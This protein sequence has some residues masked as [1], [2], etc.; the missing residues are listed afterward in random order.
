[1][2]RIYLSIIALC[3]LALPCLHAVPAKPGP[4]K[5]TLPDGTV[6]TIFL[7]G[8]EF[9][10]WMTDAKGSVVEWT[11]DSYLRPAILEEAKRE[12]GRQQRMK[13]VA[14]QPSRV[15]RS[16]KGVQRIPVILIQFQDKAFSI[17]NPQ[18]AFDKLLNEEDYHVGGANGSAR[19]FYLAN[20]GNLYQPVF[21]VFAPVTASESYL[22]TLAD[23]T[24]ESYTTKA[25]R[26]LKN[27][28]KQLDPSVDYSVYDNDN[29]GQIDMVLM[30]YA[31]YSQAEGAPH[32][33]WPH[34]TTSGLNITLDGVVARRH[35][36]T[37]ELRGVS[38]VTQCGIGPTVHEFGHAL[39]LP[40]FYDADYA[41][42]GQCHAMA[43][44][45]TM[46]SGSYLNDSRTPPYFTHIEREMLGWAQTP[47][48][49]TQTGPVTLSGFGPNDARRLATSMDGE[50]FYLEC[51][52]KAEWDYYLPSQGL[53]V[54]HVDQS[55]RRLTNVT[56]KF[57]WDYWT[58]YNDLNDYANHPL[59]YV[60]T[61]QDQSNL[62]YTAHNQRTFP[63]PWNVTSYQPLDWDEVYTDFTLEDI[64]F[65]NG[66]V[67][68]QVKE[69]FA[70]L[71][72]IGFNSIDDPNGGSYKAGDK[73]Y[74]NLLEAEEH[75]PVSVSW[76]YD[77]SAAPKSATLT[78]G[79]HLIQA[80][81][82]YDDGSKETL[83][84]EINVTK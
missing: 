80:I 25:S 28:L 74:F 19:D 2:R 42:N 59:C 72:Q 6:T 73:F 77:G 84:L 70:N 60:V 51:R 44:Y 32:T 52:A 58:Y 11:P 61:A 76:F 33:I 64:T 22:L 68:F 81:L 43:M 55:N 71:A 12:E 1:M 26:I 79:T 4:I 46:A 36:C 14:E 82:G 17:E 45:S 67:T 39:G 47:D 63:G 49:I 21:D 15:Q 41:K 31:G 40:D 78:T 75:K 30:Y 10:H 69:L 23:G 9:F 35:F 24:D 7:H 48:F 13:S 37:A 66:V 29:D 8:D 20:S 5:V 65:E 83:E 27:A 16:V 62:N 3:L 38:G 53:L 50:V 54:Y 34:Q 18:E 56:C 57:R